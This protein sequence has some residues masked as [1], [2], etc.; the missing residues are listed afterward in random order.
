MSETSKFREYAQLA[1]QNANE[2][3]ACELLAI[4]WLEE[5]PEDDD[6]L[7]TRE[8]WKDNTPCGNDSAYTIRISE[9]FYLM[10]DALGRPYLHAEGLR[11]DDSPYILSLGL[12]ETRGQLR[13]LIKLL[14][15][16]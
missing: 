5:H 14:K 13:Q 2:G 15:G 1:L 4:R 6:E 9:E 10:I 8:W 11:V 3:S 16:E 12:I 7:I